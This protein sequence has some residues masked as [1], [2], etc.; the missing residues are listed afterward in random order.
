MDF[1]GRPANSHVASVLGPTRVTDNLGTVSLAVR[2]AGSHQDVTVVQMV[3]M[4]QLVS[5]SV[6][7]ASPMLLA[8]KLTVL[9]PRDVQL[10]GNY[11]G[12][13]VV[14]MVYTDHSVT[15]PVVTVSLGHH[16]IKPMDFVCLAAPKDGLDPDVI[17]VCTFLYSINEPRREK[18]GHLHMRKQ[19]RRSAS[20]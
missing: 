1:G 16:A 18:T 14:Q 6:V 4:D 11:L 20:R 7:T 8:T 13:T 15:N 5:N 17:L 19:R 10:A 12:V 3:P 2:Q 9:A